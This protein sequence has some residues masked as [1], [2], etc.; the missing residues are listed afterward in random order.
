MPGQDGRDLAFTDQPYQPLA[1]GWLDVPIGG[2]RL[3]R[4]AGEERVVHEYDRRLHLC[5]AEFTLQKLPL[6][7]L[8][9]KPRAQ[10]RA[11]D[12]YNADARYL[13]HIER[14]I[15]RSVVRGRAALSDGRR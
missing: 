4:P 13:L 7:L 9:V 5:R 14:R 1:R 12:A 3:V 6:S 10:E 2:P 15:E 11:V 8:L